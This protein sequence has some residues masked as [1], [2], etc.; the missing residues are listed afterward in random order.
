MRR[1]SLLLGFLAVVACGG[2]G[3]PGTLGDASVPLPSPAC[4]PAPGGGSDQ[5]STPVLT[6]TL[7]DRWHEGWLASPAV[8]DLDGDGQPEL[9]VP[10]DELLL[11]WRLGAG[12]TFTEAWRASTGGRIWASPVVADLLPSRP[13]LEVAVASRDQIYAYDA[14]GQPLPGFPVTASDELR[15]LAAGDIDGDGE[16]E[17]VAVT[18]SPIEGNG[19]RDIVFAFEPDGAR[20]PGFPPNTT[21][22]AGCDDACYVT[23]G[24]DQNLAL[25]DVD[26]D[27][28][29]DVLA[30]QDNAYDSLHDG[31]GR[32]FD[33]ASIFS[34]RTKFSGIRFMV[35]YRLAQQ[36][37]A[38]DEAVD[39]QG[40]FTNTAPAIADL[41]GDGVGE[42][43]MV[44]SVQNA[45]QDDRERGV[46]VWVVRHDGT[47][48]DAWVAPPRMAD[49]L[50]GLWDAGDNVV[51][52][53]NQV[54]VA[55]L[56]PDRA[57]P[58]LVFAGFDGRI[59]AIDAR[60]QT[61]WS[62]PYT[63]Q[64]E[65][66]TGGV[67]IADLSGDGVPEIVFATYATTAGRGALFVLDAAGNELHRIPLPDRGAMPVPTIADADGDGTLDIVVSTKG[68]QDGQPQALVYAVDGA[69]DNCMPWPTGRGD[70]RRDGY[71]PPPR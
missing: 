57:G 37:Y 9:V 48:P 34:G 45:A 26:G 20:T 63:D 70:Y 59:W 49:Y 23:G 58:E 27:G 2:G 69:T 10:R 7:A 47:R 24:Y 40:H 46:A 5:V 4:E 56:D 52:I 19:Q 12:D 36:G 6:H 51:A 13:G 29:V 44:G 68:G 43:I 62:H 53:T 66:G 65:V 33:A 31:T 41:D 38:D 18:S 54:A 28:V 21:G 55:D 22:A 14:A 17:L 39:E 50:W 25:G 67:V 32:A 15:S 3:G 11:V 35:D 16:L 42:I 71:L 64:Q 1:C 61:L 8:I 30:T 60:G